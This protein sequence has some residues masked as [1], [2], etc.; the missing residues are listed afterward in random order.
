METTR[1]E[2]WNQNKLYFR[3]FDTPWQNLQEEILRLH[4][5][6]RA[7]ECPFQGT[8][9]NTGETHLGL[10]LLNFSN[11]NWD[12]QIAMSFIHSFFVL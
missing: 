1:V 6:P 10:G 7:W 8:L 4:F 2:L 11:Q 9:P 3:T 12:F 5:G